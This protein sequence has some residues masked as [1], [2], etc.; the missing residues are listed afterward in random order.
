M[1]P[2][3]HSKGGWTLPGYKYLGP[4]N[5]VN[6]G[7]GVNKLDDAA[8]EHDHA[9]GKYLANNQN[10][11]WQYNKADERMVN[12]IKGDSSVAASLTRSV[13]AAKRTLLPKMAEDGEPSSKM[14]KSADTCEAGGLGGGSGGGGGFRTQVKPMLNNATWGGNTV[15][16]HG[17]RHIHVSAP[18]TKIDHILHPGAE[19]R[20]GIVET[21]WQFVDFNQVGVHW[22]GNDFQRLMTTCHRFRPKNITYSMSGLQMMT[23]NTT[24]NGIV[25]SPWP[26]GIMQYRIAA[27]GELPYAHYGST[28]KSGGYNGPS[29][30]QSPWANCT[31]KQYTYQTEDHTDFSFRGDPTVPIYVVQHGQIEQITQD[32]ELTVSHALNTPWCSMTCYNNNL[33][34]QQHIIAHNTGEVAA[35]F[36]NLDDYG[37]EF[38]PENQTASGQQLA[39]GPDHGISTDRVS[40]LSTDP[41]QNNNAPTDPTKLVP[42]GSQYKSFQAS[43]GWETVQY[44]YGSNLTDTNWSRPQGGQG[45][46]AHSTIRLPL[47]SKEMRIWSPSPKD[48]TG[49]TVSEV[50]QVPRGGA[51]P[52]VLFRMKPQHGINQDTFL[53]LT[54][55]AQVHI[56]IEWETGTSYGTQWGPSQPITI[57]KY[58]Q[59]D[60]AGEFSVNSLAGRSLTVNGVFGP[61][62]I[63]Y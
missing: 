37:Y 33:F 59:L 20:A 4:Y 46:L 34:Q 12:D 63:L 29:W 22:T 31:P 32:E 43:P 25:S 36:K 30:P 52:M 5:S 49:K 10:P 24:A 61:P 7:P 60:G 28:I 15:T 62:Q 47:F 8:H 41:L 45:A 16:T 35:A 1:A 51:F 55:T 26:T 13:W 11:Y 42:N 6:Q 40:R 38:W 14:A 19:H 56:D 57:E 3:K 53:N 27:E 21:T 44:P 18:T 23:H 17:V 48:V 58:S 2:I 39:I 54:M 50:F 9:Y